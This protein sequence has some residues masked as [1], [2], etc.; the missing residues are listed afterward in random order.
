MLDLLY[1]REHTLTESQKKDFGANRVL[2]SALGSLKVD[3]ARWGTAQNWAEL[4]I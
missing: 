3:L 4:M 1:K 2:G